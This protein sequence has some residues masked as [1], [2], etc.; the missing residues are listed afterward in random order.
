[1]N[2]PP[3]YD[4]LTENERGA[5]L[6]NDKGHL[7][8]I[9]KAQD[10]YG[11]TYARKTTSTRGFFTFY[12]NPPPGHDPWVER[13]FRELMVEVVRSRQREKGLT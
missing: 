12:D 7:T 10:A 4:I 8:I 6:I 1:M 11:N 5:I 3:D 9:E 13:L 2:Y